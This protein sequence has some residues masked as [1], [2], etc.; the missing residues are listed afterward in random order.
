MRKK[1]IPILQPS[2]FL[3]TGILLTLLWT[4]PSHAV[5]RIPLQAALVELNEAV[6]SY[7]MGNRPEA[8]Q[9]LL[10]IAT[11][12]QYPQTIQQEARI[13]IAEILYLEGNIDGARDYFL[14]TLMTDAEYNIDRFRHP[15]EICAEFDLVN[16]QFR[17]R[18]PSNLT[19]ST[20]SN[21]TRFAP[22][23]LYQFQQG[24]NG[25]GIAYSS[26]Q[27]GTG[28]SSLILFNYLS[29]NPGYN[30]ND[31]ENQQHLERILTIQ[32]ASAVGF[33]AFWILGS[34]DAQKDWQL[35]SNSTS[36]NP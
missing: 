11:T 33:Y 36:Q 30:A 16:A 23:G 7:Q 12:P 5:E 29:Q 10:S 35:N 27:I 19:P 9:A 34:L 21:W 1:T 24:R 8:L 17:Q 22:F 28:V 18:T 25:K 20:S 6:E 14:E 3:A 15:P 32:R 31:I 26:L 13:Y 4:S 2:I